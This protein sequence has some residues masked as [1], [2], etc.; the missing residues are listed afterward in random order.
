[1]PTDTT[2]I[3]RLRDKVMR[4]RLTGACVW[5]GPLGEVCEEARSVDDFC[6]ACRAALL[7]DEAADAL[8]AAHAARDA[9]ERERD[10]L[11]AQATATGHVP[12]LDRMRELAE[13][14]DAALRER[15][16][17]R[18]ALAKA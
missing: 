18:A 15:D 3:D 9:A 2:I 6:P 16:E 5:P 10:A 14:R 8:T 4:S 12:Y 7:L 1:M 13:Q 17:A 11:H